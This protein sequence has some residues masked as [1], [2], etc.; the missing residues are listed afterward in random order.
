M[1]DGA[2]KATSDGRGI[3][4]LPTEGGPEGSPLG[5]P[6][7][8][9]FLRFM[10]HVPLVPLLPALLCN[11]KVTTSRLSP[12]RGNS[13][14]L[15]VCT[16]G[17]RR[18]AQKENGSSV[19]QKTI[20]PPPARNPHPTPPHPSPCA[21]KHGWQALPAPPWPPEGLHAVALG[22]RKGNRAHGNGT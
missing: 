10:F 4:E 14:L 11:T 12:G 21:F 3:V 17:S 20:A 9:L 5:P 1:A 6:L 16:R 15:H 8:R 7:G 13:G 22:R 18:K 19:A 2:K